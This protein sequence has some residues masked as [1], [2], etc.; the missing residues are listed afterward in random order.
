[1][2]KQV[3]LIPLASLPDDQEIY[4]GTRFRQYEIGLNVSRKED[5]FYEYMLAQIPGKYDYMLLSCVEG[6]KSGYALALVK[7]SDIPGKFVVTGKAIKYSMGV[8]HTFMLVER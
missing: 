2:K 6:P 7:T 8:E 5:D 3:E 4:M 1:M